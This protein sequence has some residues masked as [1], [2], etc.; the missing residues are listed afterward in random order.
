VLYKPT[1]TLDA[2]ALK[3]LFTQMLTEVAAKRQPRD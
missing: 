2:D 1:R 3:T